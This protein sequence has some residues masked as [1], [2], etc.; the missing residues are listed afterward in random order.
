MIYF[1]VLPVIFNAEQAIR[2]LESAL[3]G[4]AKDQRAAERSMAA[5]IAKVATALAHAQSER[6]AVLASHRMSFNSA[7][8]AWAILLKSP[9]RK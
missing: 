9:L 5:L 1:V 4:Y 8:R 3:P 2:E 6:V 7:T